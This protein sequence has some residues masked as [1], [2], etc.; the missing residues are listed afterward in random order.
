MRL[1]SNGPAIIFCK[2]WSD[3]PQAASPRWEQRATPRPRPQAPGGAAPGAWS[4]LLATGGRGE[5]RGRDLGL[6]DAGLDPSSA[7]IV[8]TMLTVGRVHRRFLCNQEWE[9]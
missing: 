2:Q 1:Q 5:R 4:R 7:I 6:L 8:G 9:G 3:L